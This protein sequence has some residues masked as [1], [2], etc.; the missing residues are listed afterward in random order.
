[1]EELEADE[2]AADG[3]EGFVDVVAVFVADAHPSVLVRQA[4]V[5]STTQRFVPSPEP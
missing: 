1:V 4:I 3:E 2:A 5:R